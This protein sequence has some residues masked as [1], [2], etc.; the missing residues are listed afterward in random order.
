MPE[1]K[2]GPKIN[3]SMINQGAF[4]LF[5]ENFQ[6]VFIKEDKSVADDRIKRFIIL[7]LL[8]THSHLNYLFLKS[9][10]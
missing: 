9:I 7:I 6:T 10:C 8:Y 5:I 4:R 1:H 2:P 3:I